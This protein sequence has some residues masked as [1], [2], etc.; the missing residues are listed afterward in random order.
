[1]ASNDIY[2]E[3][4]QDELNQ[5]VQQLQEVRGTVAALAASD[6]QREILLEIDSLLARFQT[7]NIAQTLTSSQLCELSDRVMAVQDRSLTLRPQIA[8]QPA[9]PAAS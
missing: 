1:M 4:V 6:L 3:T 2:P 8:P 5:Y 7:P 9:A